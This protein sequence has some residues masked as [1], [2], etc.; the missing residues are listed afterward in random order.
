MKLPYPQKKKKDDTIQSHTY[1]KNKD[2][3]ACKAQN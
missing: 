3:T 2:K 1:A